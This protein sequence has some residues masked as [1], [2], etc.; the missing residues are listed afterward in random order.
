MLIK[1]LNKCKSYLTDFISSF[2]NAAILTH[3]QPDGDGLGAALALQEIFP[4]LQIVLEEAISDKYNFLDASSRIK[5]FQREMSYD[6]LIILDC[7]EEERLGKCAHLLTKAK[8][9]IAID[10]HVQ[11]NL[12]ED[13]PTFIDT[14]LASAGAIIYYIFKEKINHLQN[15]SKKYISEALY[16]TILNDTDNFI[17]ANTQPPTFRM[18]AELMEWGLIPGD[19]AREFLYNNTAAE[20]KLLGQTLA[21][22]ET[23]CDG[24]FLFFYTSLNMLKKLNLTTAAT[25]GISRWV[26]GV[27]DVIAS[28]RLEEIDHKIYKVH[29][30]SNI[31]DVNKIAVAHG[32]GGHKRASGCEMKGNLEEV[33]N[34]LLAELKEQM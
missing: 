22:I 28:I 5:I 17:N 25:G 16:T 7:H 8:K 34:T 18:C 23:F 26:K 30:R 9:I 12:I 27:K 33:R 32:G 31:L 3:I 13:V 20:M 2:P 6:L 14:D 29:L 11:G 10:H 1:T 15:N 4:N 24:K 21:T 19:I